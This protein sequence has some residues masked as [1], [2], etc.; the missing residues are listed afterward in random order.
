MKPEKMTTDPY[1]PSVGTMPSDDI[2]LIVKGGE[3]FPARSGES[4]LST[5][6]SR[7]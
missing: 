3:E 2:P 5:Q 4:R 7:A 1:C 6:L